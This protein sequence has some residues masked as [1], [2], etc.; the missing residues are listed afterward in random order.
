MI[1]SIEFDEKK[2]WIVLFSI[3][4]RREAAR[5]DAVAQQSV[6]FRSARDGKNLRPLERSGV[7]HLDGGTQKMTGERS[8]LTAH[9][10]HSQFMR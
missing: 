10:N 8:D 1:N 4:V 3:M 9:E 6:G 7:R 5:E 2:F